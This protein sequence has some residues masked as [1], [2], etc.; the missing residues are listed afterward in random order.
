MHQQRD[1]AAA[2]QANDYFRGQQQ[3]QQQQQQFYQG[4]PPPRQFW[5]SSY[6]SV[7]YH[8]EANDVWAVWDRRTSQEEADQSAMGLCSQMMGDGC[9][10]ASGGTGGTV[11]IAR[12]HAGWMWWEWGDKPGDA[13]RAVN[14]ACGKNGEKCEII[15]TVTAKHWLE[16]ENGRREDRA[17]SYSPNST[18]SLLNTYAMVAWPTAE[19]AKTMD[20]KWRGKTW[21]ISGSK[22][23]ENTKKVL[24]DK[25]KLDT[26]V[27][28]A[29]TQDVNGGVIVQYQVESGQGYW[30]TSQSPSE[31]A[32]RAAKYCRTMETKC[33]VLANFDSGTKRLMVIAEP[34]STPKLRTYSAVAWPQVGVPQ[35]NNLAVVTGFPTLVGAKAKA[36]E[37]CAKESGV[38]CV[39][40]GEVDQGQY[41]LLG[42]YSDET[43]S[44]RF[45]QD[46]SRPNM[47]K[48]VKEDCGSVKTT[49]SELKIFDTNKLSVST[50]SRGK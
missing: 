46:W 50:L 44:V 20:A 7:V 31:G 36:V 35:W 17:Q 18:A 12:D 1:Q 29:V 45:Y 38:K 34:V 22:G 10:V 25:C 48:M 16:F 32:E 43:K 26:R 14:A 37:H 3:Q 5:V 6:M 27:D 13:T 15:K 49:C 8:P 9:K 28:C 24:M 30:L 19:G 23:Y 11:A 2:Q 41:D 40:I 39:I 33:K 21:L 4:P 42:L 47:E